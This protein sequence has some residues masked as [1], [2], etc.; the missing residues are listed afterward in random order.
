MKRV[1]YSFIVTISI[2]LLNMLTINNIHACSY[3]LKMDSLEVRNNNLI[4]IID[5]IIENEKQCKY[6]SENLYFGIEIDSFK[7]DTLYLNITSNLSKDTY[8]DSQSTGYFIYKGFYFFVTDIARTSFFLKTNKI[9]VF[10]KNVK[11]PIT[12]E[13]YTTQIIFY[14]DDR[15][16]DYYYLLVDDKILF[17]SSYPPCPRE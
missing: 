16:S 9:K 17:Y 7:T 12:N 8:I 6:F 13:G 3:S 14:E 4:S 10:D 11:E 5:S 15:F 2:L 1:Y